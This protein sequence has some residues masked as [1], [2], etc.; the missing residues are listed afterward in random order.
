MKPQPTGPVFGSAEPHGTRRA[1]RRAARAI[2]ASLLLVSAAAILATA[3]ILAPPARLLSPATRTGLA[4]ITS[5][6]ALLALVAALWMRRLL[7]AAHLDHIVLERTVEALRRRE[8]YEEAHSRLMT[9]ISDLVEVF[10]RTRNLRAVLNEAVKVLR[11]NLA[12]AHITLQLYDPETGQFVLSIEEGDGKLD[13]GEEIRRDVIEQG[14]SRLINQLDAT[15]RFP[16]LV[17]RGFGSLIVAPL[18]R[19]RRATD[20][21]IGLVAALNE[22]G[23]DFTGH[24]LS[25]L[26]SF[27]RHAGLIIENAQ[28][29]K[30][31]EHLS[32]HDGLTDLFNHRHFVNTLTELI[33]EARRNGTQLA[34][35]M[36]DIDNFKRYNDTHGHPKGDALLRQIA[37]ILL[38]NTRQ[39]DIVARYGGEEFV[40]ILPRTGRHGARRVAETIRAEVERFPFEGED[41]SGPVTL[42]LGVAVF[43]HDAASAEELI[44]KADEALYQGKR[45][46]K[47]RVCWSSAPSEPQPTSA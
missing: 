47:N 18:A 12:V 4:V 44:Q 17:A 26:A 27:A 46:G 21:S 8:A 14:K 20:R 2:L 19:G 33:E 42:T 36:S 23:K 25:L 11:S 29:Y 35:I 16:D 30:H 22:P 38:E 40:I 45:Q 37:R 10:T 31:A 1:R 5:A 43:P 15:G 32:Q 24:E 34:L 6:I 28:L 39:D 7:A 3:T 13:L 9:K 41:A